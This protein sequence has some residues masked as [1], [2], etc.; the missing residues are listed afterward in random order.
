[1]QDE[2]VVTWFETIV[3]VPL[4][5]QFTVVGG[6]VNLIII[7]P[8]PPLEPCIQLL[9]EAPPPPPPVFAAPAEPLR[10][11]FHPPFPPPPLPPKA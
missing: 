9:Y 11:L 1:M 8:D 5:E 7:K 3:K 10:A 6:F 2:L 4:V